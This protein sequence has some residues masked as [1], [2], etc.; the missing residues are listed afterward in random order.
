[1]ALVEFADVASDWTRGEFHS[2]S[3]VVSRLSHT[4]E[5]KTYL[6]PRGITQISFGLTII[7][8]NSV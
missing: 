5:M 3:D 1:M 4:S 6:T 2:I 8:P 7:F